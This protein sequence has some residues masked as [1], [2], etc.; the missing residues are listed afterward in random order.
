MRVKLMHKFCKDVLKDVYS[1]S[2]KIQNLD[3]CN[4]LR[5]RTQ[6]FPS[7]VS[8]FKMGLGITS[9]NQKNVGRGS[10]CE[11]LSFDAVNRQLLTD[12]KMAG[13]KEV[14]IEDV[15]HCQFPTKNGILYIPSS[16]ELMMTD[17]SAFD[18]KKDTTNMIPKDETS[19]WDIEVEINRLVGLPSYINPQ[20]Q[21]EGKQKYANRKIVFKEAYS[22]NQ[23]SFN[24]LQYFSLNLRVLNLEYLM[25]RNNIPAF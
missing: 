21:L 4:E 15:L 6:L 22:Y 19:V 20:Y 23:D 12:F 7:E 18:D 14:K 5:L 16:I 17:R 8:L 10:L 11:N 9:D 25:S 1:D 2:I 13:E 24:L 3:T